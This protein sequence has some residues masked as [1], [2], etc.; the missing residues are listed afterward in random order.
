MNTTVTKSVYTPAVTTSGVDIVYMEWDIYSQG[1][2]RRKDYTTSAPDGAYKVRT[3]MFDYRAASSQSSNMRDYVT[4]V[5]ETELLVEVVNGKIDPESALA[6]AGH[7]TAM[8]G[9]HGRYIEVF[10]FDAAKNTFQ[11]EVGS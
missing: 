1:V 2:P 5:W 7:L 3:E 11:M 10:D 6:A 4:L 9:Y 8:C